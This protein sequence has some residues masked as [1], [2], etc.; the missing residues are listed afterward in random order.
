MRDQQDGSLKVLSHF[1]KAAR[2]RS[3]EEDTC[4]HAQGAS[5]DHPGLLSLVVVLVG[6]SSPENPGRRRV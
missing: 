5:R 2:Q 6:V 3:V 4:Q 1:T